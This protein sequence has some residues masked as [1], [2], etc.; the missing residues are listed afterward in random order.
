MRDDS[1]SS[2]TTGAAYESFEDVT[3]DL[4]RFIYEV[5]NIRPL[6]SALGCLSRRNSRINTPGRRSKP[7]PDPVHL[8]GRISGVHFST[9]D[10]ILDYRW[11]VPL[12]TKVVVFQCPCGNP[13][14]AAHRAGNA[15]SGSDRVD[16]RTIARDA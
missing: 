5:Y 11:E 16:P 4:P 14:T 15:R 7:P 12:P 13:P 1:R 9:P 10:H 2:T 3:A 8:Q 6:H